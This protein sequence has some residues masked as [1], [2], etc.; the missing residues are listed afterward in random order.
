L[1]CSSAR[2]GV[3]RLVGVWLSVRFAGRCAPCG[4]WALINTDR[5]G[6]P[7]SKAGSSLLR[8]TLIRTADT[9]RRQDPQL[10]RIYYPQ[11]VER[12]PITSRRCAWS[13]GH[14][15]NERGPRR[16]GRCRTS[17]AISTAHR[18][19]RSRRNGSSRRTSPSPEEVRRRRRSTQTQGRKPAQPI[20]SSSGGRPINK[21]HTAA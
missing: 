17:S 5:K 15:P 1:A 3:R 19:P 9:A 13:P 14:W 10:A 18:S 6:Q 11:M 16:T 20:I 21:P 7:M 2:G 12:A 8:T 4:R